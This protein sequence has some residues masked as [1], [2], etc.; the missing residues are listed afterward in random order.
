M[1][2]V[3]EPLRGLPVTA[4]AIVDIF[5]Q[6]GRCVV[7]GNVRRTAEIGR[8]IEWVQMHAKCAVA[9]DS[10]RRIRLKFSR[11][12]WRSQQHGVSRFEELCEESSPTELR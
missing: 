9:I 1:R 4:T 2:D 11:S 7:A 8:V 5:N 12:I 6:I 3:L 10:I